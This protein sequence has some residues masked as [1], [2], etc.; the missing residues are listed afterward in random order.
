[1]P[2]LALITG[3]SSGIGLASAGDLARAG[4]RVVA[5]MRNLGKRA[6][7]DEIAERDGAE[8]E[9]RELDV[10]SEDSI[11]QAVAGVTADHGAIDVLVNNAGFGMLGSVEQLSSDAVRRVMETNFFGVW[12]LTSAVFPGMRERRSG[13][14]ITVTSVG[15]M[16]GQPFNDSYCAAKFA[17]EGMMECLAPV[18]RALGVMVSVVEPGPVHTEFV[19][20][21]RDKSADVL[22]SNIE[23]YA[24]LI[25]AYAKSIGGV[26]EEHGQAAEEIAKVITQIAQTERPHLRYATSDYARA[27]IGQKYTDPTGDNVVDLFADRLT[28][29]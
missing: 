27:F 19:N 29:S 2:K 3:C 23:G 22:T 14:I 7:I 21:T 4:F 9:V 8:I 24:P 13:H 20:S 25:A 18:G 11:R 10:A 6:A 1:M 28:E 26:F 15:G 12:N 16:M 17:V 5:T